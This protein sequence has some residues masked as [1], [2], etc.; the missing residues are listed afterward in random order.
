MKAGVFRRILPRERARF[1]ILAGLLFANATV[2]AGVR[3]GDG[4]TVGAMA[5]V[6]GDVPAGAFVGGVPAR[7]IERRDGC[8][9]GRDGAGVRRA[10]EGPAGARGE[11]R[12]GV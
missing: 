8:Y 10:A 2:L 1:A 12:N 6:A 11:T 4:A 3:I 9:G 7:V 5:L